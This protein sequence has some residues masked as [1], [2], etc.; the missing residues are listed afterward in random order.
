MSMF[1]KNRKIITKNESNKSNKIKMNIA[2]GKINKK[3]ELEII[4]FCINI[5]LSHLSILPNSSYVN[6]T[7]QKSIIIPS[8]SMPDPTKYN[9]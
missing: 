3:K 1:S 4:N 6:F 7:K 9:F 8:L 2:I 5:H